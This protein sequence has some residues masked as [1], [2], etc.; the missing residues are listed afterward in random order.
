MV[1]RTTIAGNPTTSIMAE[2]LTPNAEFKLQH[3][4]PT[5]ADRSSSLVRALSFKYYIHDSVATLR[6]QLIG[7][8]RASNI[9]ELNGSWET[10]RTTLNLRRFVLDV[11]QL[12]STDDD[13]RHWLRRINDAGAVF[14]P[15]NYLESSGQAVPVGTPEQVAA[16]KLSLLGRVMGIIRGERSLR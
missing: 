4:H 9:R 6:F 14:L 2:V 16:V 10:A 15:V 3:D 7:D 1:E 5:Q 12:F 13:G 11:T 8:L